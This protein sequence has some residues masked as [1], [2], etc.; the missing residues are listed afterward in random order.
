MKM[1]LLSL[2][3]V[4]CFARGEGF[5][6]DEEYGAMLFANPRGISCINCHNKNLQNKIIFTY[7]KRK[8]IV[9]VVIPEI[10]NITLNKLKK[11]LKGGLIM[12]KYY[13]T[14]EEIKA[15]LAFLNKSVP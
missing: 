15:L 10:K 4:I 1:R 11:A 13:F 14:D 5:I 12:P 3:V 2:I 6:S 8:K 9:Q 7:K